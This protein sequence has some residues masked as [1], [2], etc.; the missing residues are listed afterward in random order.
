MSFIENS[1]KQILFPDVLT[2]IFSG[3]LDISIIFI[4]SLP[5]FSFLYYYLFLYI[6]SDFLAETEIV[7]NSYQDIKNLAFEQDFIDYIE[8]TTK[9]FDF[10][11]ILM[12]AEILSIYLYFVTLWCKFGTTP[13]KFIF[14][15]KIIDYENGG[16]ISFINSIIRLTGYIFYP[17]SFFVS[18][19]RKDKR[20]IHDLISGSIVVKY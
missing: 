6:F 11:I 12:L 18:Y 2:R 5:I 10:F 16:K 1:K 15:I 13:A 8:K 7:I 17:I 9:T 14:N 20:G 4:I 3:L 19:F